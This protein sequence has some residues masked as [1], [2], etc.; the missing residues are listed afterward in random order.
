MDLNLG[1]SL[2]FWLFFGLLGQL[3]FTMRFVVQWI[4][5]E[6]KKESVIPISFW[7]FSLLGSLILLIYAIYRKDPVFI[8]GQA[9]GFTVYI[10]N[11][12]LIFKK[13]NS[14]HEL[15]VSK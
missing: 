9:F 13:R 15:S 4:A 1:K 11:L 2:N 5:S 7:A 12:Q 3:C 14:A 10:R 6:K 8:L